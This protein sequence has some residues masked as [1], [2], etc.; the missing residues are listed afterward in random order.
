M[1]VLREGVGDLSGGE[2]V[3]SAVAVVQGYGV[4]RGGSLVPSI[5]SNSLRGCSC[6]RRM[7]SVR[8]LDVVVR[9]VSNF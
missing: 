1:L 7:R 5:V 2:A 4:T 6:W 9:G 8:V 3:P